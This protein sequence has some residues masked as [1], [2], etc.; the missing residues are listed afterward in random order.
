ML[1]YAADGILD[2][3]PAGGHVWIFRPGRVRRYLV[4]HDGRLRSQAGRLEKTAHAAP[5]WIVM[6]SITM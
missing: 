1:S 4:R 6:E 5:P 2:R 3:Q